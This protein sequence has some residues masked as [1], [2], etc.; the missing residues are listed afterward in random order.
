ML[1]YTD[2]CKVPI[3]SLVTQLIIEG[4]INKT[5]LQFAYDLANVSFS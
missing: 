4:E 3:I 2:C 1:G 5:Y